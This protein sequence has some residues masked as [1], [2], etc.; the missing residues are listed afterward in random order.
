MC[1]K[2]DDLVCEC[3]ANCSEYCGC[4]LM[5]DFIDEKGDEIELFNFYCYKCGRKFFESALKED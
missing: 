2:F 4:C 3:G 5:D 1:K